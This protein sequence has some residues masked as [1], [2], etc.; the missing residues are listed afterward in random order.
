MQLEVRGYVV[1]TNVVAHAMGQFD[2]IF[3][4]VGHWKA[5]IHLVI[6]HVELLKKPTQLGLHQTNLLFFIF[7]NIGCMST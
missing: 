7:R 4:E 2:W 1:N 6:I 5:D 3:L